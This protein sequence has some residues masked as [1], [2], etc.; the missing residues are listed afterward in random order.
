MDDYAEASATVRRWRAGANVSTRLVTD[1]A[2]T[3]GG[4]TL[5]PGEYTLFIDL[6]PQG[7]TLIVST[8][9]AQLT[10]DTNN[11]TALFGA[12]DYTPGKDVVR[13]AM[14]DFQQAVVLPQGEFCALL[15]ARPAERR[16]LV[17]SL[18]EQMASLPFT[19]QNSVAGRPW[20]P[21]ASVDT[22]ATSCHRSW[23]R[24]AREQ[25]ETPWV[26]HRSLG[27]SLSVRDRAQVAVWTRRI[28]EGYRRARAATTSTCWKCRRP[29]RA[30]LPASPSQR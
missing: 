16:A 18:W 4:K 17:A 25:T 10:Y 5:A 9:P 6:Q 11:K 12:Y 24:W 22:W 29:E 27:V 30:S 21:P 3:I 19:I 15:A 26:I 13:V 1:A 20:L 23:A 7:W 14:S 8:W 28:R 2:L